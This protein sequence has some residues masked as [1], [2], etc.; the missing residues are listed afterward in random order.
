MKGRKKTALQGLAEAARRHRIVIRSC[1]VFLLCLASCAVILTWIVD[2][3]SRAMV[4]LQRALAHAT[5]FVLGVFGNHTVVD[6]ISVT[7]ERF[8]LH[9]IPGCTALFVLGAFFSAVVAFPTR[10][11]PRIMG[12]V[13]GL[14][15]VCVLNIV[16][17]TSLFYVGVYLP[18]F[19]DYAHLLVWQSVMIVSLL[20]LWLAWSG[21]AGGVPKSKG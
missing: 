17:L 21:R 10:W 14:G 18:Q 3:G 8:T 7:S 6:G 4:S 20:A 5:S 12:F 11:R 13:L 9:V 16:R 2:D 1:A 19:F 15:T